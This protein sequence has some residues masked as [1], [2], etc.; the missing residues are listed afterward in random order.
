VRSFNGTWVFAKPGP[1]EGK[2][3]AD[4]SMTVKTELKDGA[5]CELTYTAG[6]PYHS[7]LLVTAFVIQ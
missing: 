1:F 7:N 4:G 6:M 2:I 3:N 5:V